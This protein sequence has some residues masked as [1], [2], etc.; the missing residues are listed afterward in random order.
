MTQ[1]I[2][3]LKRQF[4][5]IEPIARELQ[6]LLRPACHRIEIAGSIRRHRPEVGDIELVAIPRIETVEVPVF[7]SLFSSVKVETV[8]LLWRALEGLG[9]KIERLKWGDKYRAFLW[10][11]DETRNVQVDLFTADR[12]NWGLIFLIRTG[13]AEYSR[14]IVTELRRHGLVADGGRVYRRGQNGNPIGTPIPTP[15][16]DD[17]FRMVKKRVLVPLDRNWS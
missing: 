9:D 1:K 16:E 12:D 15:E 6:S 4:S 5:E 8:N 17:I 10:P 3:K 2:N 7:E 13:S 11:T 14:H